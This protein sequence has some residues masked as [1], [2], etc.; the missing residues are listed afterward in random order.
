MSVWTYAAHEEVNASCILDS[1]L[2]SSTFC[3]KIWGIAIED[4]NILLLDIDV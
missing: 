3:L 2:I 1:L 4:V